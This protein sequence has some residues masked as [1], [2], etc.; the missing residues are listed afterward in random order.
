MTG[1]STR[2]ADEMLVVFV[3][4]SENIVEDQ[5]SLRSS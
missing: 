4:H 3:N 1:K 2:K 5:V